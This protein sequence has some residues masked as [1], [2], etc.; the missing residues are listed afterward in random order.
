MHT[1]ISVGHSISIG[2]FDLLHNATTCGVFFQGLRM[3]ALSATVSEMYFV[4]TVTKQR[5]I[6]PA[7]S[8]H[9]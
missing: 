4:V 9:S 6:L 5:C 3:M 2:P 8:K 1:T 7:L